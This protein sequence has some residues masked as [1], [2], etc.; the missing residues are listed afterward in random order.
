MEMKLNDAVVMPEEATYKID[1]AGRAIIPAH[2]R[3]KFKVAPGDYLEYYTAYVD[4]EWVLILRK[5]QN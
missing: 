3:K 2:L 1:P 5:A 4:C